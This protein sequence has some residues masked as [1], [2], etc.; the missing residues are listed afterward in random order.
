MWCRRVAFQTPITIHTALNRI[1]QGEY[2]LPAIQREFV[3]GEGK[4]CALFDS[5]MRGYPIG[6]FLFWK[7]EPESVRE[8]TFYR[9]LKDYHEQTGRHCERADPAAETGVTAIL[10][11]QQRLTSLNVG[12]RGSFATRVKYG[13]KH[14]PESYP[15]RRLYLNLAADASEDSEVGLKHEF[16][17][18]SDKEADRLN[19]V[20]REKAGGGKPEAYWFPVPEAFEL[21][22]GPPLY[23]RITAAGLAGDDDAYGRLYRLRKLV[24]EEP[25]VA[26]YEETSQDLDKVL[27]IFVRVNSGGEQ[28][29]YSDLLLSIATAGWRELDAR[30]AVHQL[31]DDLNGIGRGGFRFDK[32][33]V[34]K[35]GL[36]LTDRKSVTFKVTSFTAENVRALERGWDG[37]SDALRTAARL[38][39]AFGFAGNTLPAAS[40]LIP[41]ADYLHHRGL[42]PDYLTA[43]AAEADRGRV[44]SWVLRS[45]FKPG[46]VWGSGLDQLLLAIRS[47]IRDHG[48]DGFPLEAVEAA[49]AS[50]GKS[51]RFAEEDIEV[52]LETKIGDPKCFALLALLFGHVDTR[53]L[54]HRDHVVPKSKLTEGRLKKAGFSPEDAADWAG[55]RDLL[56]NLQL[57]EGPENQSKNAAM[58]GDWLDEH[59]PDAAGRRHYLD[60]YHMGEPPRSVGDF[61]DFYDDRRERLAAK[62]R[63][64][65]DG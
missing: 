8:Y 56:P 33:I 22:D 42:G 35:S 36:V 49:M 31:V 25:V 9:F 2:I 65:L 1:R 48:A 34:L 16:R 39:D 23:K 18:L 59:K 57:L 41:V 62:L 12:L 21:P 27:N 60:L 61:P 5:L 14:D 7:V 20:W 43:K 24:H 47:A 55:R 45:I 50:R 64:L 3:W 53:N 38:L 37:V 51:L 4:I 46:G 19:E 54:F 13:R 29:S 15:V 26:F 40:V 30:E 58:P 11:G 44:K 10:D 28:L 17:F 32:D 6:S 52:L 63:E